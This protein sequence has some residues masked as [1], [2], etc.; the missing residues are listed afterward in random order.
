MPQTHEFIYRSVQHT[1]VNWYRDKD[2]E[3]MANNS[4]I[5]E[6][7]TEHG[8]PPPGFS[9]FVGNGVTT[10]N[11]V[12]GPQEVHYTI[13]LP[14]ATTIQEAAAQIDDAD[15]AIQPELTKA[16]KEQAMEEYRKIQSQVALPGGPG[17]PPGKGP[18]GLVLPGQ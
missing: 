7:I 3:V 17:M 6:R 15:A 12:F 9:R 4:T 11:T 14:K 1:I 10:V 16:A 8:E 18:S 13:P 2:N 5:V